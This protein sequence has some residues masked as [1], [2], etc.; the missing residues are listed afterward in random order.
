L[1]SIWVS[2]VATLDSESRKLSS[3]EGGSCLNTGAIHPVFL[4]Y[5]C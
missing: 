4:W 2:Q 3:L 5:A 1:L